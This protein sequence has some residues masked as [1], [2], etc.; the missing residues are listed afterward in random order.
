MQALSNMEGTTDGSSMPTYQIESSSE[1][2]KETD[3]ELHQD[4]VRRQLCTASTH[5]SNYRSPPLN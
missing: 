2:D 1:E 5:K 3:D 4:P